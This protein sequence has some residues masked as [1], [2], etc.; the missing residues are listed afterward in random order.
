MSN[1]NI[2]LTLGIVKKQI[3]GLQNLCIHIWTLH[4]LKLV[5]RTMFH[6]DVDAM[7][8]IE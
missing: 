3:K 4:L 5:H 6:L 8:N 7:M 2:R 1:F